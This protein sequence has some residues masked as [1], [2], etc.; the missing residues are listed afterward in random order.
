[1][2]IYLSTFPIT[3]NRVVSINRAIQNQ[4]SRIVQMRTCYCSVIWKRKRSNLTWL[5]TIKRVL[6]RGCLFVLQTNATGIDHVFDQVR[7]QQKSAKMI[8]DSGRSGFLNGAQ[9]S[10]R[11]RITNS[12]DCVRKA[13]SLTG[14]VGI[15]G[16]ECLPAAILITKWHLKSLNVLKIGG[17]KMD[18]ILSESLTSRTCLIWK[19]G[20]H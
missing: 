2:T 7:A 5:I 13:L 19:A 1:M 12:I 11:S 18:V 16:W 3:T 10:R 20:P 14:W 9:R 6:I 8:E 17:T 15:I 4:R